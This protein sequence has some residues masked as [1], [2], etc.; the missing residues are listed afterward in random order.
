MR[1]I[2]TSTRRLHEFPANKIP[3]Y[4]ILSHTWDDTEPSFQ[5]VRTL[6][7]AHGSKIDKCCARAASDGWEYFWIDTCCINK[8]SSAELSEAINSMLNWYKKSAICYIYLSDICK[9]AE[10]DISAAR[11]FGRGW[12]LQELLAP[13]FIIFSDK[14]WS[15]LGTKWGLRE[16]ITCATRIL[17]KHLWDPTSASVAAK[18]SW[19]S[20]RRTSLPEDRA[21]SLMGLFGVNMPL[22]YGEGENAFMRLQEQVIKETADDSIFAWRDGRF[23]LGGILAKSP[24]AFE[25]SEDVVAILPKFF[26]RRPYYMTNLGF[27]IEAACD[28]KPLREYM[29]DHWPDEARQIECAIFPLNCTRLSERDKCFAIDLAKIGDFFFRHLPENL[30]TEEKSPLEGFKTIYVSKASGMEK[31]GLPDQSKNH[32]LAVRFCTFFSARFL[33][34]M[35][36][37][38][39]TVGRFK[40]LGGQKFRWISPSTIMIDKARVVFM[41]FKDK[42]HSGEGFG[43]LVWPGNEIPYLDVFAIKDIRNSTEALQQRF[44][45][46]NSCFRGGARVPMPDHFLES[47]P[48]GTKVSVAL[49]RA[50]IEHEI[51]NLLVLDLEYYKNARFSTIDRSGCI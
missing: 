2:H 43:V 45:Q 26:A 27:A 19:A 32:R 38:P 8:E 15:E 20:K 30:H 35:L 18:M 46:V 49:T 1:L 5:D 3:P 40:L 34:S 9:D 23:P 7:T 4:A 48:S 14:E 6:G 39:P 44:A 33:A 24:D 11:W 37:V 51:H 25:K 13:P 12:T 10:S 28:T 21:Y 17:E 50:N 42:R 29:D 22:L 47:L 31:W 41:I 16:K 36:S